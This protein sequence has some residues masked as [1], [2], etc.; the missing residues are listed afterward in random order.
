M[1]PDSEI[2]RPPESDEGDLGTP[3]RELGNLEQEPSA[4]FVPILRKKIY[5]RT[6]A[7]QFVNFTWNVPAVVLREMLAMA[8]ELF[9]GNTRV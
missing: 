3:A 1:S 7:S 5:R 6:A 2:P 8:V 9:K 4:N